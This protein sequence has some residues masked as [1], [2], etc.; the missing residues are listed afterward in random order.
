[1]LI[2]G[3][4]QI[5][6]IFSS[7]NGPIIGVGMTAFSRIVPASFLPS[8]RIIC[9]QRTCD[10]SLLREK[11]PVFCLGETIGADYSIKVENSFQLLSAPG[12]EEVLNL[13]KGPKYLFLYQSYPELEKLSEEKGWR[14]LANP[15]ELR[16]RVGQRSFFEKTVSD[17]GLPKIPGGIFPWSMM[18]ERG[19]ENWA[20]ELGAKFVVQLPEIQKGGGRGTFFVGSKGEYDSLQR[21]LANGIWRGVQLTSVLVRRFLEGI[22]ASVAICATRNG[23]L[24]SGLQ[25]QLIDLPYCRGFDGNGVFCGHVWGGKTWPESVLTKAR[26]Q[27][28]KVGS[29]L[30]S[31]GYKGIAGIDFI[32]QP[33]EETVYPVEINP[34]LT[35]AFP[36]LSLLHMTHG[37]APMEAFHL[38]EFLNM[39]YQVDVE[40]LNRQFA[41]PLNGSHFLVFCGSGWK[42]E[43][44]RPLKAGIW[45]Y[46]QEKRSCS[47]VKGSI[48]L[49]EVK[50][51]RQFII[52]DGPPDGGPV[53][54]GG[55]D[56]FRRLCRILFPYSMENE[57]RFRDEIPII[58][59]WIQ[60]E[61]MALL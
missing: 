24:I 52:A 39:P 9:N 2:Q 30:A 38:L 49:Q 21:R 33:D 32:V 37:I 27:A 40:G 3:L 48:D 35:G 44:F 57:K 45:E 12:V 28:R 4:K 16:I 26:E 6:R 10:L 11:V 47:F 53:E 41:R 15:S 43:S 17:L 36:V 8:Y 7:L 18:E 14:L 55:I 25:E 13:G 51:P 56:P 23:M 42:T 1:M 46:D 19:Y 5:K 54:P 29:H 22:P 50:N 20:E 60:R 58:V 31:L 59:E 34:R 61:C